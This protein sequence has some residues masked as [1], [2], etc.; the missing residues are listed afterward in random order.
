[1]YG[2]KGTHLD[3]WWD[4]KLAHP[5]WNTAW[6]F[7]RRPKIELSYNFSTPLWGIYPDTTIIWKRT[8][9]PMFIA[10][11]F[12]M[13]KTWRQPK[14]PPT[15]EWIKMT[16]YIYTIELYLELLSC[17]KEWNGAICSNMDG[18]RD[19]YTKWSKRKTNI[20]YCLYVETVKRMTTWTYMKNRNR[21]TDIENQLIITKGER[22]RDKLGVW[23]NTC[24]LQYITQ[25][26]NK[27]YCIA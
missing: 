13:A 23:V 17:E 20:I 27:A 15:Y 3:C 1:M 8:C 22:V 10:S 21:L 4:C 16:W 12:I 6:S 25:I 24:T 18:P 26:N 14:C 19:Y 7:L 9:T 2:E 11:L 5:L